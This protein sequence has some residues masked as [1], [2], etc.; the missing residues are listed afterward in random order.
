MRA[1]KQRT[2]A[3][4]IEM[5]IVVDAYG[6]VERAMGW[7][8]YLERKLNFPFTA[9]C[10][11]KRSISP[12]K[13]GDEIE[14]IGMPPEP[15]CELEMLVMMRWKKSGLGVPLAQLKL[16]RSADDA[17]RQAVADWHYWMKQGYEF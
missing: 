6:P 12:L 14:V 16:S 11:A 5:E 3:E 10:I 4:R 17:T 1:K 13:V 8:Y 15:D 7:Y 2:R 9:R